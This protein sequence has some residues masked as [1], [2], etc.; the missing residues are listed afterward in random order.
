MYE[1]LVELGET[2][3]KAKM[4]DKG[5]KILAEIKGNDWGLAEAY[6]DQTILRA[7][8]ATIKERIYRNLGPYVVS[9][10]PFVK[11]TINERHVYNA[12][13]AE[14]YTG[15]MYDQHR[16]TIDNILL[17]LKN[18]S[19]DPKN[20]RK[21]IEK[22]IEGTDAEK[23]AASEV[24]Q[25]LDGMK[26]R[27]KVFM[28]NEYKENLSKKEYD[29][30]TDIIS[31]RSIDDVKA[32]NPK[33]DTKTLESIYAKYKEIDT[34][35]LDNYIPNVEAG[36]F[37]V[38]V[39][40][41]NV[42]GKNYKKLV[43]IGLSEKDAIRKATRYA[44]EH[45]EIHELEIDTD[46]KVSTDNI[47]PITRKQYYAMMHSLAKK[48]EESIDGIDKGVAKNMAQATMKR[49]FKIKPTDSYSPF[50]E[51]RKDILLGE[52]DIFPVLK[53]YAYS[54]EKKMALDPVIEA[55]RGDLGK[56]NKWERDYIL[57]YIEDVK[58][59][60]GTLDKV[61]DDLMEGVS[62]TRVAKALGIDVSAYR[63]YSRAISGARTLEANLKLGYR[64][65]AAGVNF[66]SGQ[67]HTWVKR[68][69][70]MYMEGI[71][72][73]NTSEGRKLIQDIEP[74]LGTNIV[75]TG[76]SITS[77]TP[78]WKP[79]GMFQKAEPYNREVSAAVAYVQAIKEGM[80]PEAAKM[81]A[82]RSNWAEQFTYN[83]ANLPK[84][85]R[86]PTGKLLT[87]FKPYLIKEIEFMKSL[88]APE[89]ARYFGMQLIL[90]GP[91]AYMLTLKTLPILAGFAFWDDLEEWMNKEYPLLSRGA[92]GAPG[93]INKDYAFDMSAA[94]SFQFPTSTKDIAGPF[95][96]DLLGIKKNVID[97][98]FA[99]GPYSEDY[100][101]TGNVAPI[102][103]HW[104]R[105]MKFTFAE[106]PNKNM[107]KDEDGNELYEVKDIIPLYLQSMAGVESL[108]LNMIR[109]E[110]RIL[111][112][113]DER[114][115]GH[116]TRIANEVA[117]VILNKKPITNDMRDMIK[118][119]GVTSQTI[120]NRAKRTK[121]T[122]RQ[123][124][125]YNT[126]VRRRM[127]VMEM[128]P[129]DDPVSEPAS[130][131]YGYSE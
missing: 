128:F 26:E 129:I 19:G 73:L 124:A 119:Y 48:M 64:P 10:V 102:L 28:L 76:I 104:L 108:D 45:P 30:L 77:K 91:R 21:V 56:M 83:I 107:L 87:Q 3:R 85:M 105:L 6:S 115:G 2:F 58:G 78:L 80:T 123:R 24:R 39:K 36:R 23:Q 12:N 67:L 68:G 96:S 1:R 42:E 43:A 62:S 66:A 65:V 17:N 93:L 47:T 37:K 57:D 74:F 16:T 84:I 106:G 86:G 20:I 61:V 49:K 55:I 31:G 118:K 52:E 82:I 130:Q 114:I 122:P 72:F 25:W 59:R 41:T 51:P 35:G 5:R 18:N 79:L 81:F 90:G 117:Q 103:K 11:G 15:S 88:S 116:K 14:M 92:G 94:A 101:K 32:K 89:W 8:T 13:L 113:R 97:P 9:P 70:P 34:W 53:S 4:D 125:I 27:Y 63:G 109:A 44:E 111:A 50:L 75:D 40:A 29:V 38:V 126:E 22:K 110:E 98:M 99:F 33:L 69:L 95:I 131:D 54:L 112:N 127:E 7:D 120:I 46:F 121:M 60:Y 100:Q 71:K